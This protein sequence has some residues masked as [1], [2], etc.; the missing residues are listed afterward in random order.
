L[1]NMTHAQRESF[2]ERFESDHDD[3]LD[4]LV[5]IDCALALLLE[6]CPQGESATI[7]KQSARF[8]RRLI[9]LYP[10]HS[11]LALLQANREA[12]AGDWPE[13]RRWLRVV[14]VEELDDGYAAYA[15][16]L[17]GM[18][19]FHECRTDEAFTVLEEASKCEHLYF[20]I[21]ELLELTEP[22]SDPPEPHEWSLDRPL[23][24]QLLGA[25]RTADRA[26]QAGDVPA[27]LAALDRR[28]VWQ[29]FEW[30]SAAR[31]AAV[32]LEK[33]ARTA[34]E[35]FHKRLVL[36]H[37]CA[38]AQGNFHPRDIYLPG[39]S[40]ELAKLDRIQE[41]ALAWLEKGRLDAARRK[42]SSS[43]HSCQ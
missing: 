37:F 14:K 16:Y 12:A 8:H 35:R 2:L 32:F 19:L 20:W 38:L 4:G 26:W 24:R 5:R 15:L 30:Q 28:A 33:S 43:D 3:D 25:M 40:W 9:E 41:R 11:V 18:A 31:L 10:E 27:V 21:G 6:F 36:A 29:S 42:P 22:M 34:A 17:R 1:E 23:L 7:E 39:V 13:V